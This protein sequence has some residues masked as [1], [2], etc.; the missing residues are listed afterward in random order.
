VK[1]TLPVE[2]KL[3]DIKGITNCNKRSLKKSPTSGH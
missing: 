2:F 1:Y 3:S